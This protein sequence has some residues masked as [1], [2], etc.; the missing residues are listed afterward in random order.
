MML[1]YKAWRE[2][3]TRFLVGALALAGYC[4]L[5]ASN[6]SGTERA[7]SERVVG[8]SY[9]EYIDSLV[10]GGFGKLVFVLPVVFLG[11]GGLL[12][13]RAHHT[14]AFTLALPVSRAQLIVSQIDV[15]LSEL[16]LLAVV[17]ALVI[18]PLSA[19][20][21]QSYPVTQALRYG[22]LRCVC[23]TFIF[24]IS[25]LLS[26]FLR[27]AYTAPMA[28]WVALLLQ[29]QVANWQPLRPYGLN[30]LRTIDGRWAWAGSNINDPLPWMDLSIMM[31]IALALF[32]VATRIT[33]RQNL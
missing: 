25:F 9:G 29:A 31:L 1:F 28:C 5:M 15:G 6:W 30:P 16:A 14:A 2:S 12:R 23:G 20:V 7:F 26:V 10:F 4:A 17:P 24:A 32:A 11:L 3:Q 21:H 33:Q 27:G 8:H 18:P 13:E 22:L 19:L